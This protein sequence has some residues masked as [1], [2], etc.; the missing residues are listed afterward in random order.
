[1][2][3]KIIDCIIFTGDLKILNFRITEV[4]NLVDIIYI[5]YDDVDKKSILFSEDFLFKSE[6]KIKIL[7]CDSKITNQYSQVKTLL[8]NENLNFDDIIS[9]SFENELPNYNDY[10]PIKQLLSFSIV[11]LQQKKYVWSLDYFENNLHNGTIVCSF[12]YFFKKEG[13]DKSSLEN[14]I[15]YETHENGW[16]FFGFGVE[17]SHLKSNLLPIN[18]VDKFKTNLLQKSSDSNLFEHIY[19]FVGKQEVRVREKKIFYIGDKE[20]DIFFDERMIFIKTKIISLYFNH[21]FIPETELY[22]S[23]NFENE[24]FLNEVKK[25]MLILFPLPHDEIIFNFD[26]MN[27]PKRVLWEEVE[28][29]NILNLLLK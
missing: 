24:Y 11:I 26:F 27:N 18:S 1:M 5:I 20:S 14:K 12:S 17:E 4:I 3:E 6:D 28:S 15:N 29:E 9:I 25:F 16:S 2:K 23:D 8:L 10:N 7:E 19:D 22:Q 13:I 21:I